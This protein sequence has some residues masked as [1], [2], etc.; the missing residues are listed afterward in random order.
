MMV[1]SIQEDSIA[2][3]SA[4]LE[5]TYT[6]PTV[7]HRPGRPKKMFCKGSDRTKRTTE[8]LSRS[9]MLEGEIAKLEEMRRSQVLKDKTK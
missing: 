5:G 3:K 8:A 6:I 9:F 7:V 2:M 1:H 4:R